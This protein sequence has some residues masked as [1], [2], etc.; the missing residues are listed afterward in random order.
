MRDRAKELTDNSPAQTWGLFRRLR[1]RASVNNR[2]ALLSLGL[3][4]LLLVSCASS[5]QPDNGGD[6]DAR[7]AEV[8][9]SRGYKN[10]QSI[11]IEEVP[12]ERL[13][14]NGLKGL[15]DLDDKVVFRRDGAQ[16]VLAYD[17]IPR[18]RY[19]LPTAGNL[20]DWSDLTVALVESSR[21]ESS[22]INQASREEIYESFFD[23][24]TGQLDNFSHYASLEEARQNRASRDGFGGIGVRIRVEDEGVRVVS[25]M[26]DTPAQK[27]GLR[28][29][30]L[31]VAVGGASALLLKQREA[32]SY[33]RGPIGSQVMVTVRRQGQSLP[34]DISITRQ[35]VV[36]QTVKFQR[37]G[38]VAYL[39]L[40]GFNADTTRA[41]KQAILQAQK[42]MGPELKGYILDMRN[43]PGGILAEAIT[44][45]DLFISKG[46]IVSTGGR[47]QDSQQIFNAG[48]QDPLIDNKPLI[49]LVNGNSA[50][51]AEIVASALQDSNV[52]IVVGSNSYGKGTVQ[53]VLDMP[54]A[55]ELTL[56]WARF[57]APSGYA[58]HRRGVLPD[59][60]TSTEGANSRN[61]VER[62]RHGQLSF[63]RQ[64]Q[65]LNINTKDEVA[66]EAFRELC[67]QRQSEN[68]LDLEVASRLIE[69][70]V[71]YAQ[72][73]GL[74][75]DTA[76][77][78]GDQLS[79]LR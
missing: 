55:G 57:Y 61:I 76:A 49:A 26:D 39:R 28:N 22:R 5:Y 44:V 69:D 20:D 68:D 33:L 42:Q 16:I 1:L 74:S 79:Q 7:F 54:N 51:A 63:S 38:A 23:N 15:Q 65:Q 2:L 72:A 66:L 35:H 41:L 78:P 70:P 62:L 9:F 43:N 34:L 60:C 30:D 48:D 3:T 52:A 18:A 14:M 13:V 67:P 73:K 47:H 64:I 53:R 36:P 45:S 8:M 6:F 24:V 40:S 19:P 59:I 25:V 17:G 58:L 75:R 27:S 4:S 46:R 56:T 31:I 32:V 21:R 10:V 29:N 11:Y 12:P 50:S 37:R 77:K 71:L